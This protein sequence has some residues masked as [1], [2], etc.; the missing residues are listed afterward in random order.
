[1][2]IGVDFD[3]TIVCYDQLFH[4]VACEQG[5]IPADLPTTKGAVCDYLRRNGH[6]AAWTAMQGS[7]YGARI[8]DAAPFPGVVDFFATCV[9]QGR[10]IVIISHKTRYPFLGPAYDL[11]QAAQAWLERNGFY[12]LAKIGLGRQHV[13][14]E[15]TKAAKLARIA[16]A[17][18]TLFI[19]DLPEFLAEPDFPA[20]VE[21]LLF[22]P[23]QPTA[24]PL[25]FQHA[26][27][28]A[29]LTRLVL[30]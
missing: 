26:T 16:S 23:T 7:V 22:A 30:R 13:Y 14:F 9:R 21:R 17:G 27:S 15:L 25:P 24:A 29:E 4:R 12:D 20:H 18:C 2:I 6:E 19:D 10:P 5:L 28:W 1:M 3:N 8:G 11:H